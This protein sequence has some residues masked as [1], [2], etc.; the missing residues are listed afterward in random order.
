LSADIQKEERAH[1]IESFFTWGVNVEKAQ[2]AFL[3]SFSDL[4][5]SARLGA[6]E[7]LVISQTG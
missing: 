6:G 4:V 1:L 3:F 5:S 7:F 2:L